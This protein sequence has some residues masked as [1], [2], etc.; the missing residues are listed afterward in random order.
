MFNHELE[1]VVKDLV[2]RVEKL[3][4]LNQ[5][6]KQDTNPSPADQGIFTPEQVQPTIPFTGV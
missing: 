4:K 5:P 1:S 6:T 2:V 3:E